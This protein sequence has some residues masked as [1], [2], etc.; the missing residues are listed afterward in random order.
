MVPANFTSQG[1]P[2]RGGMLIRIPPE[3]DPI[4]TLLLRV[5]IALLSCCIAGSEATQWIVNFL[6][7]VNSSYRCGSGMRCVNKPV[8]VLVRQSC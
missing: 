2:S 8:A 3:G 5:L 6:L 7:A 1:L 4:N